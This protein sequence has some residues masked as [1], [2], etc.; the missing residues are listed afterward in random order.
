MQ[1]SATNRSHL[2]DKLLSTSHRK[3]NEAYFKPPAIVIFSNEYVHEYL[4]Y[5]SEDR[6]EVYE[7]T[8]ANSDL[9]KIDVFKDPQ[10]QNLELNEENEEKKRALNP[11]QEFKSPKK[12]TN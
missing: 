7:I 11:D 5:L 10:T 8:S 9:F 2:S 3:Y 12:D 1:K 6:W 4:K